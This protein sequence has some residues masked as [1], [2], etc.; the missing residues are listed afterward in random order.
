MNLRYCKDRLK[1]DNTRDKQMGQD[2]TPVL[3]LRNE[4]GLGYSE[5][6]T[7]T[8]DFKEVEFTGQSQK[9]NAHRD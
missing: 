7:D 6:G 5:K 9:V 4:E 2:T 1:R 8:R 3:Q